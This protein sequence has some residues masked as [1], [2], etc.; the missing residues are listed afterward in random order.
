MINNPWTTY[1]APQPYQMQQ[2]YRPQQTMMDAPQYGQTTDM[3]P[4]MIN[5]RYVTCRE[6]MVAAQILPDGKPWLFFDPAHG[7]V[8]VKRIDP[9]TNTADL[10][11]FSE[12]APQQVQQPQFVGVADFMQ[13]K[14]DF[15]Q[16]RAAMLNPQQSRQKQSRTNNEEVGTP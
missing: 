6:E 9:Q 15:E 13:L 8:Y 16:F 2:I 5:A 12:T 14:N 11:D 4:G 3:Q 10:R 7:R 1:P